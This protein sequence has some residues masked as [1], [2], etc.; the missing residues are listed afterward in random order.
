[1]ANRTT[2]CMNKTYVRN[3]GRSGGTLDLTCGPHGVH[4]GTL[5]TILAESLRVKLLTLIMSYGLR[6]RTTSCVMCFAGG[7]TPLLPSEAHSIAV[8][9]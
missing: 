3:I 9:L 4:L 5:V 7:G 6:P 8:G 1:M 2:A